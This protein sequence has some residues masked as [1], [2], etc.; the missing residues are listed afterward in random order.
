MFF[1]L[2]HI[3]EEARKPFEYHDGVMSLLEPVA[4]VICYGTCLTLY[5]TR[6]VQG[7][8]REISPREEA[9]SRRTK[10]ERS[11]AVTNEDIP[12]RRFGIL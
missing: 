10:T 6:I 12:V 4:C 9:T 2:G 11:D 1:Q 7:R 8:N 5:Y 3:G